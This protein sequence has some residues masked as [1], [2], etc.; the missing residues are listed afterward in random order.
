MR[1]GSS[2]PTISAASIRSRVM[3]STTVEAIRAARL[4]RIPCQPRGP[5][6]RNSMGT[7]I[8]RTAATFVR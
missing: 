3:R 6:P 2:L 5:I 7:N 8:I 1:S 4:G